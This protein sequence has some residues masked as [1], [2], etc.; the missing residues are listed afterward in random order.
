MERSHEIHSDL[1][2]D[3]SAG[4]YGDES[5]LFLRGELDVHT[6]YTLR[7]YIMYCLRHNSRSICLDMADVT[8]CDGDALYGIAGLQDGLRAAGGRLRITSVSEP[9]REARNAVT[10]RHRIF[11]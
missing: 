8:R 1:V 11:G 9:V 4:G 6:M 7:D 5:T 2:I 3:L 10:M